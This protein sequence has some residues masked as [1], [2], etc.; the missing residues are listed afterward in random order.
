MRVAV[1][2]AGNG[3]VASAFDFAQHGHEVSLYATPEFGTNVIAVKK[4]G[5]ITATGALEGFAAV[6]YAGHDAGEA[7][8]GAEL[9]LIVGPGVQHRAAGR[10]GRTAS[11]RGRGRP[12][13][14]GLVRRRDRVQARPPGSRSTTSTTSSARPA[15]CPTPCGSPSRE[16]S[17]SSSSSRRAVPRRSAAGG[18]GPAVR[19]G[20]GRLAGR[21]EGRQRL[22]D[23]PPERQPGDPPGGHA[24]QR[25]PPRAD[26]RRLPVLRGG[27]DRERRPADRGGR[28][29]AAGDRRRA[30]DHDPVRS[31]A[32]RDA[33]L[34][35]R[36]ELL[37]RATARR[38][39]SWAS[40]R[41]A[42]SST[43]T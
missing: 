18:H 29:R 7:L 23:H 31:G 16:S 19:A 36:G 6:R 28:P 38:P 43:A 13:L 21:R 11:A 32:R 24:A 26:R 1:L 20:R 27:R 40:A 17:T 12:G 3:G 33:G 9:V 42:S 2:G 8:A 22:P 41:R 10:R 39:A 30:R 25:R 34:H 15:P 4:A 5:G 35:E 14:P 37:D